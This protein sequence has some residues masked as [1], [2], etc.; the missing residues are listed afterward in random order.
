MNPIAPAALFKVT[1]E[2]C[3]EI[4]PEMNGRV[5][6]VNAVHVARLIPQAGRHTTVE[7][8]NGMSIYAHEDLI[9]IHAAIMNAMRDPLAATP[10]TTIPN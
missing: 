9:Q 10:P 2:P 6:E 1:L 7:M 3:E 4:P 5:I 8:S